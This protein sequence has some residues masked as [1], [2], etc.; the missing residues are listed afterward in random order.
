LVAQIGGLAVKQRDEASTDIA[1]PD[2]TQIEC[3]D[4]VRS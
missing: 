3:S 2:Q 1:K 4:K